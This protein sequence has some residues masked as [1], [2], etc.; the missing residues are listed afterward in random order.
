MAVYLLSH[1]LEPL[2]ARKHLTGAFSSLS[3]VW[4]IVG[5]K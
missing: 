5:T 1:E 2:E 4:N 3:S